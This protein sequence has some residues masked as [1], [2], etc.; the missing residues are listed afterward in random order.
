M[1][2]APKTIR[3]LF[4]SLLMLLTMQVVLSQNTTDEPSDASVSV[5]PTEES[6]NCFDTEIPV[7]YGLDALCGTKTDV[8][9][10]AW[11]VPSH[12]VV[13]GRSCTDLENPLTGGTNR[14]YERD[15]E[16]FTIDENGKE[17]T[18]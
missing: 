10:K 1:R 17:V 14:D 18:A 12:V 11:T 6:V 4:L 15:P 13:G 3:A 16:T 9:G 7:R 8:N 5:G 2:H